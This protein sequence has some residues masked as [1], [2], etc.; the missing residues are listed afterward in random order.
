LA[1]F[2]CRQL[3][4]HTDG[5]LMEWRRPVGGYSMQMAVEYGVEH[6]WLLFDARNSSICLT[7]EGRRLV[8]KTLS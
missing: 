2:L 7:D 4:E 5:G 6:G 1:R 8:R 3:Y